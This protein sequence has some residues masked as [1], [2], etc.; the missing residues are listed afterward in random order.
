MSSPAGGIIATDPI[1]ARNFYL[2]IDAT[3]GIVLQ[4]VSSLNLE[5]TP[6]STTQNGKG[7]KIE[8]VKT[9]GSNVN[10]PEVE[11]VRMAPR[12]AAKDPLWIWYKA[13]HAKGFSGRTQ[14]RKTLSL[15]LY[16]TSA[17][18]CGEFA[19]HGAWP[20]K[21]VNDA[22]SSDSNEAMKETLTFVC[23]WIERRK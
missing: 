23:E 14:G 11:M 6:V 8:H 3:S 19:L 12:D 20:T 9:V 22:L 13:I 1:V 17:K 18:K 10:V 5:L 2:E 21:I 4:S 15:L 7:G 16:D